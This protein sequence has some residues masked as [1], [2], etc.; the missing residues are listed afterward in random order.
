MSDAEL[1]Q[2]SQ[3]FQVEMDQ[4][5]DNLL[6]SSQKF[7]TN[8]QNFENMSDA[9]LL[10]QSQL[11]KVEIDQVYGDNESIN[12]IIQPEKSALSKSDLDLSNIEEQVKGL[13]T[14][15]E[16]DDMQSK[17]RYIKLKIDQDEINRKHWWTEAKTKHFNLIML[18]LDCRRKEKR[19]LLLERNTAN[20][21]NYQTMLD[22]TIKEQA[23]TIKEQVDTIKEQ[24]ETIKRLDE[25]VKR[26][27]ET[28]NRLEGII[29]GAWQQK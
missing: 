8:F 13:N 21:M 9:E 19:I 26:L 12:S 29:T 18:T 7:K 25:S 23:E 24:A 15:Q 20:Y 10:Q 14:K 16:L 4:V 5:T 3:L 28:V 1:L 2:Q 6:T 11:L 17:L 27:N 22:K